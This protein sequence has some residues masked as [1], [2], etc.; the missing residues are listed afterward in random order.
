MNQAVQKPRRR[1][2]AEPP[3][4]AANEAVR[5]EPRTNDPERTMAD[6]LGAK[7]GAKEY[8]VKSTVQSLVKSGHLVATGSTTTRRYGLPARRRGAA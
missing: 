7:H 1:V 6:I 5:A 2:K 8:L 4:K 3:G